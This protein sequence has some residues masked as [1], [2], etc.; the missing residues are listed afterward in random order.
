MQYRVAAGGSR[1]SRLVRGYRAARTLPDW[2]FIRGPSALV[3]VLLPEP[4]YPS[5]KLGGSAVA[6][7]LEDDRPPLDV[8]FADRRGPRRRDH[9]NAHPIAL[10]RGQPAITDRATAELD[11]AALKV[12]SVDD[13]LSLR[14]I[15]IGLPL[16]AVAICPDEFPGQRRNARPE[17][18]HRNRHRDE[19]SGG[20]SFCSHSLLLRA[21]DHVSLLLY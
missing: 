20:D 1:V 19:Q 21:R 4:S 16:A 8:T 7:I 12:V 2:A 18:G 15:L 17:A 10:L 13:L 9:D 11:V 14:D 6:D 5:A 3:R